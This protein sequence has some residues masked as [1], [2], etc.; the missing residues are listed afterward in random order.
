VPKKVD[1]VVLTNGEAL[2]A[3]Y[4][5][6]GAAAVRRALRAL[7]ASDRRK[8][9]TSALV[10]LDDRPAMRR[11]AGQAVV[12]PASCRQNK[13]AVDAVYR[14]LAPDYIMLAGAVDI[15]PHQDL[16]NPLYTSPAGDDS[17]SRAYGDLPYACEASYSRDP[18][19]FVGPTRVVGR[20]PDVNGASDPSFFLTL[21]KNATAAAPAPPEAYGEHFA[22]SAQIWLA[23]TRLSLRK[24]FGNSTGVAAVPPRLANWPADMLGRRLHL[25]NCHGASRASEFFGQP[26][27]G[28][29][30]Y[31]IALRAS[32]LD[33][34]I[35]RGTIAA[36]ECCYGAQLPPVSK[37]RPRLGICETYLKNGAW[38]FLGSTTIA[39]GDFERNGSADLI[40][41][42]FL[43][44]VRAGASLGRAALEAR[45]RFVADASPIN[46]TELKT[47]AQ[48]NVYG[49]PSITPIRSQAVTHTARP[50]AGK[51]IAA[52]RSERHDRRRALFSRGLELSERPVPRRTS[53]KPGATVRRAIAAEARRLKLRP[54]ATLSFAI[55]A[56]RPS[57]SAPRHLFARSVMPSAYH[58]LFCR[59]SAVARAALDRAGITDIV[60]LIGQEVAGQV[61]SFARLHS[62]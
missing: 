2:R 46:P 32:Y 19:D 50:A 25:I 11:L 1:K 49:D 34:R 47:I 21:L 8:G 27:S 18:A 28:R 12:N 51:M 4:G 57:S 26:A 30:K 20:L 22:V 6:R 36:V 15:I 54:G 52:Q 44:A 31:P 59:R 14:S 53:S 48:F 3:K 29:S 10:F 61:S 42:Y 24:T 13:D 37:S 43:D 38:G 45:Q 60:V 58:V 39:Y 16:R 7:V 56:G 55:R 35:T 33:G 17:D 62:R 9:L 41:Q 23:S 40:C 5:S